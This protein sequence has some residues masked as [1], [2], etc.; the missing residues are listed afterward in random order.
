MTIQL[1]ATEQ[2]VGTMLFVMLCKVVLTFAIVDEIQTVAIQ[3]EANEQF[4]LLF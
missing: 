4:F 3:I 2:Y 1:K